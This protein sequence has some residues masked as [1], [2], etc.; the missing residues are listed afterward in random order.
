MESAME[1]KTTY[2]VKELAK[3]ENITVSEEDYEA[4]YAEFAETSGMT[5]DEVRED[6]AQMKADGTLEEYIKENK[7]RKL[8][9]DNAVITG[10]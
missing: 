8:I 3:Q 4:Q 1:V 2:A 7:V 10:K 9:M 5:V 6:L